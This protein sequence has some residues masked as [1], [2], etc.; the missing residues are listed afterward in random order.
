MVAD[1]ARRVRSIAEVS[2]VR[3]RLSE[4]IAYVTVLL[5][6][7][8]W[9]TEPRYRVYEAEAEIIGKYQTAE[10]DFRLINLAEYPED[11]RP[12]LIPAADVVYSRGA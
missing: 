8:P 10:I 7:K 1:F 5:D 4:G 6:K 11:Q 12:Y 3:S 9:D 2:G